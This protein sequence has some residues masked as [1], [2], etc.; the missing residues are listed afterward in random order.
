MAVS[1]WDQ[2]DGY[3]RCDQTAIHLRGRQLVQFLEG[4][5]YDRRCRSSPNIEGPKQSQI[6]LEFFTELHYGMMP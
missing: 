2:V 1:S 5:I 6:A 3:E 4:A